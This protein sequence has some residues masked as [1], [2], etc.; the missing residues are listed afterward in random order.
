MTPVDIAGGLPKVMRE[1]CERQEGFDGIGVQ[2]FPEPGAW[3]GFY[4]AQFRKEEPGV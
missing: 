4:I 3:D 1:S 2:I